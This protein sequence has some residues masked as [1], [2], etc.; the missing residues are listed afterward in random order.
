MNIFFFREKKSLLILFCLIFFLSIFS[1]A[2]EKEQFKDFSELEIEDLL[3]VEITTAGKTMEKI[4]K[5]P[6]S[7][8]VISREQ[9]ERLG[10][11]SLTEILENIPGLYNIKDYS[12]FGSNFGVRGFWSG[13]NNDNMIILVNNVHQ[14]YDYSSSYPLTKINIPV[15][16]IDRIEVVRGPM[17]VVYGSGAFYGVINIFTNKVSE[18]GAHNIVSFSGGSQETYRL[19][20]RFEG[21][22]ENFKYVFNAGYYNTYGIDKPVKKMVKNPSVLPFFGISED[23]RTGG[24]LEE[25]EKYFNF[26]GNFDKF[27]I[28]ISY[29]DSN[30]ETMFLMPP[31]FEGSPNHHTSTNIFLSYKDEI[32]KDLTIEGKFTYSQSRLSAETDFL[33]RGFYGVQQHEANAYELELNSFWKI[34]SDLDITSG[35]YYRTILDTYNMY[36]IPSFNSPSL[37]NNMFYLPDNDTIDT[38]AFFTQVNYNPVKKL[39]LVGGIRVEQMPKY[40]LKADLAGG[41]EYYNEL[42][43]IYDG[44]EIEIIPRLAAI[45]SIDNRNIIKFLYGKATN[46]PSFALNTKNTLDPLIEDLEPESIDTLEINYLTAIFSNLMVNINVFKN[47]LNNLITRVVQYNDEGGYQTWSDNAGKLNTLGTELRIMYKPINNLRLTLSGM[48]QETEDNIDENNN[49][50]VAYSPNFL[51][52]F[53]FSY[54]ISKKISFAFTGRYVDKMKTYWDKTIKNPDGHWGARIGES[55]PAYFIINTNLRIKDIFNKGLYLNLKISN[56]LDEEIRYPT[57]TNN[58]WAKRGTIDYGRRI[59]ITMGIKF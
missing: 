19:F 59:L 11:T 5:I 53:R 45:Y 26:S 15:E 49:I 31:P 37:I 4:G 30:K 56:L 36:D 17:S 42:E 7:V 35:L 32:F 23:Y 9:I 25:S 58:S 27:R 40:K 52:Y 22:V 8:M 21:R 33:F 46:R 20:S 14:V 47:T 18:K 24:R 12:M 54:Y 48:Y 29:T 16:A 1:I 39:K 28:D 13:I 41:T 44:D 10:Y 43:G 3:N 6:A 51:G 57:F 2:Q 50:D 34:N 38:R 55:S